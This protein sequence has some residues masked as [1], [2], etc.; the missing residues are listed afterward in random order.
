MSAPINIPRHTVGTVFTDVSPY[1]EVVRSD[2][3]LPRG[4]VHPSVLAHLMREDEVSTDRV[5]RRASCVLGSLHCVQRGSFEDE[6]GRCTIFT[7][8]DSS[9]ALQN[10]DEL[11]TG[12]AQGDA[13]MYFRQ[14]DRLPSERF[15]TSTVY[16]RDA[17]PR[18]LR[19][20][21]YTDHLEPRPPRPTP[22]SQPNLPP[23]P[24]TPRN[25]GRRNHARRAAQSM[26]APRTTTT[27]HA[28]HAIGVGAPPYHANAFDR[29]AYQPSTF[30]TPYSSA[31]PE[32][33]TDPRIA[34]AERRARQEQL[35]T[36]PQP[37]WSSY[38]P[39]L[40]SLTRMY[41]YHDDAAVFRAAAAGHTAGSVAAIASSSAPSH[42]S[43]GPA[44]TVPAPSPRPPPLQPVHARNLAP[45]ATVGIATD[46][47]LGAAVQQGD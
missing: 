39:P 5:Y 26:V 33:T 34:L 15:L 13:V 25:H 43:P 18:S 47:T 21:G 31:I 7:C 41:P 40:P 3:T 29:Y 9:L 4:Y 14:G 2:P 45:I 22:Y 23:T 28:P 1:E 32:R 11:G 42:A 24:V 20:A 46:F 27:M 30:P 19:G 37:P 16:S 6:N 38:V 17:S 12:I 36:R 10:P 8:R 44:P 35:T